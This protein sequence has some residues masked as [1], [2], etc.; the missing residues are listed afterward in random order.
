ME[1]GTADPPPSPGRQQVAQVQID[2]R[3]GLFGPAVQDVV[4]ADDL[5]GGL[6]DQDV[7]TAGRRLGESIRKVGGRGYPFTGGLKIDAVPLPRS[8][9]DRGH[10]GVIR[11]AAERS[12]AQPW[13]YRRVG[14]DD[15][16]LQLI[17][18]LMSI[19]MNSTAAP[20][21]A[22]RRGHPARH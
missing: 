4:I 6:G 14:Q 20:R 11:L 8:L 13:N 12:E 10:G 18:H 16:L 7:G 17:Y 19:L 5:S 1:Q 3:T 9:V 21:V 2:A 22:G 15:R